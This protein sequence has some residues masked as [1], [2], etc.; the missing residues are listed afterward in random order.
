[1][2]A[3][4]AISGTWAQHYK[5]IGK[6]GGGRGS[7]RP[8]PS[9]H[10]ARTR[11]ALRGRAPSSPGS[12]TLRGITASRPGRRYAARARPSPTPKTASSSRAR[13]GSNP[14]S[15]QSTRSKLDAW[16]AVRSALNVSRVPVVDS[17][18][19]GYGLRLIATWPARPDAATIAATLLR[20]SL[21]FSRDS[22]ATAPRM[23]YAPHG[24]GLCRGKR[25]SAWAALLPS[26]R[27]RWQALARRPR[28]LPAGVVGAAPTSSASF[29]TKPPSHGSSAPSFS[30][31]TMS[32]PPQGDT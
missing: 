21:A 4:Q 26:E 12:P 13:S 16:P 22:D 10:R 27:H 15:S 31:R 32:G 28:R 29:P 1:M 14:V 23:R 9:D 2:G 24:S 7:P 5:P 3:G 8:M 17:I 11:P 6:A 25:L 30:S 19:P 18:R 20:S